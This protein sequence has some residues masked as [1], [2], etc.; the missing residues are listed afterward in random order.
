LDSSG[1]FIWAK[2]WGG[3]SDDWGAGVVVDGP[4]NAYVTGKFQ[5]TNVDFDPGSGTDSHTSNGGYDVFLTKFNSSGVFTWART[6]G[7]TT[8]DRGLGVALDGS[9][10]AYVTG[11]F[12]GTNVDFDP[13][14][15]TDYHSSSNYALDAFLSKFDSSGSFLLARTWGGIGDDIGGGDAVD[16]SG[17]VYVSGQFQY[18]VDFDPGTGTDNHTVVGTI[19]FFLSKFGPE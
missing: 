9:G 15:G 18:T 19:D 4:G 16:G 6:W 7:G 5:G 14:S 8:D 1:K 17:N 11:G 13:G 12:A 10:T 3:P 2:T